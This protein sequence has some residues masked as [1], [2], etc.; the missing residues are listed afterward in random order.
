M[1]VQEI[2]EIAGFKR[3]DVREINPW[4]LRLMD[5]WGKYVFDVYIKKKRGRILWNS[6]LI[7]KGERW[8]KVHNGEEFRALIKKEINK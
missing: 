5:E 2:E 7:W 4:Q 1:D 6:I 3:L 8:T